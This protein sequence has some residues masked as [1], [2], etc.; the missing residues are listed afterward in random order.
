M[1]LF[2]PIHIGFFEAVI[3][4]AQYKWFSVFVTIISHLEIMPFERP[5]ISRDKLE[6]E[7]SQ[8]GRVPKLVLI[9]YGSEV[10]KILFNIRKTCF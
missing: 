7:I 1:S 5:V 6:F 4:E 8:S 3:Q 2:F 10:N 9:S